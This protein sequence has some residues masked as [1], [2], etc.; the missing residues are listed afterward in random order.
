MRKI[1]PVILMLWVLILGFSVCEADA[2]P[3]KGYG[4]T[5]RIGGAA[6]ALD[7]LDGNAL[8][9]GYSAFI[10][11]GSYVFSVHALDSDLSGAESDPTIINPDS[12]AGTKSW[13]LASAIFNALTLYSNLDVG[14][15]NITNVAD[16][17]LDSISSD[18]GASINV[19]LGSDVG[20]NFTIDTDKVVVEGDTGDVGIGTASPG[21]KLEISDS[22]TDFLKIVDTSTPAGAQTLLD[23]VVEGS[24][25]DY[26]G[27]RIKFSGP[28]GAGSSKEVARIDGVIDGPDQ[29]GGLL[30]FWTG[31]SSDVLTERMVIDR[32]GN[33]GIG[34]TSPGKDLDV[35][36]EIRASTG[37]L[38]GTDTAAANTLDDYEEGTWTPTYEASTTDFDSITY[39]ASVF[40]Q[41]TKIGNTVIVHGVIGTDSIT[42]GSAAGIV[43]I[44]GLPFSVSDS[45]RGNA[46]LSHVSGFAGD[47]P[48]GGNC[49]PGG[50]SLVY[51]TSVNGATSWLAPA[52]LDTGADDNFIRFSAVYEAS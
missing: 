38:F 47:Y 41:Y 31:N 25:A 42:M 22:G 16:I 50:I 37:I 30:K 44:S 17:A 28:T 49:S 52:D 6:G 39:D 4:R 19:N 40:G 20:D 21:A 33:V 3:V 2:D 35:N 36:G 18:A 9:E 27:P 45:Y 34:D 24:T 11:N 15:N 12:N 51:R 8:A 43:R 5:A 46:V 1:I 29:L 7:A 14:D 48:L 26:R 13:V 10:V 23:L 32:G